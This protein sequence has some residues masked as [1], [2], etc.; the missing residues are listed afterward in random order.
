[1]FRLEQQSQ[2]YLE[3][4]FGRVHPDYL[5]RVREGVTLAIDSGRQVRTEYQGVLPGGRT[6]WSASWGRVWRRQATQSGDLMEAT[7]DIRESKAIISRG[8]AR[9][10]AK[11]SSGAELAS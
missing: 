1:M 9:R 5:Q 3:A 8:H 2:H 6:R 10:R 4:V 11:S 7:V